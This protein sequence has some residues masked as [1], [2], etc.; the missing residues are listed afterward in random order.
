[1]LTLSTLFKFL[2]EY[3]QPKTAV[4]H[5]VYNVFL[6]LKKTADRREEEF[7]RFF[8]LFFF[9]F[10]WLSTNMNTLYVISLLTHHCQATVHFGRL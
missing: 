4:G 5:F 8:L 7:K 10:Y 1:M 3:V 2:R 9:F 6:P